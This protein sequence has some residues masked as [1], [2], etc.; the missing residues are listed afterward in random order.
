MPQ[1]PLQ[2]MARKL[3]VKKDGLDI[4]KQALTHKS[5]LGE[6]NQDASNEH[7]EFLGNWAL[8]LLLAEEVAKFSEKQE[9]ELAKAKAVAVSEPILAE[10]AKKM[11]L[12]QSG[13]HEHRRRNFRRSEN[14]PQSSPTRLRQ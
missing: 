4:L 1:T 13:L 12:A 8:G 6:M 7:L 2:K 11:G 9:G 3:K 5:Y 10:A 14:A